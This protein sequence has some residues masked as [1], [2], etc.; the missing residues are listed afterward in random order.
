LQL[1]IGQWVE[2]KV[3]ID[4]DLNQQTFYYN[5]Q[6]L[7]QKSWTE[8]LSGGGALNIDAVDLYANGATAVYYDD[9]S[10]RPCVPPVP[11]EPMTWGRLKQSFH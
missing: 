4:L 2:I 5:G 3:L 10:L 1:I 9:M 6:V 7:Y 11:T 8:G